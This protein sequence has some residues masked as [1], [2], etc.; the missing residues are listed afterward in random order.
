[1]KPLSKDQGYV[2][3]LSESKSKLSQDTF[4]KMSKKI[5]Q[6]TKVIHYLHSK[7]DDHSM[8]ID[9]LK[10]A[11]EHEIDLIVDKYKEQAELLQSENAQ[12]DDQVT[13]LSD[14]LANKEIEIEKLKTELDELKRYSKEFYLP[15]N[16]SR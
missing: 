1:M 11:Y 4:F 9:S 5:A 10:E 6:L 12:K 2:K 8:H 7:Q 14:T 15:A 16:L 13:E 3:S